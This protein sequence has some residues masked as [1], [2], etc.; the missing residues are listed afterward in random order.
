MI[1]VNTQQGSAEWH[2]LRCGVVTASDAAKI[3]QPGAASRPPRWFALTDA[4]L[5]AR[6]RGS[7]QMAVQATL[8][9]PW[10][11]SGD[12]RD[13]RLDRGAAFRPGGLSIDE[14]QIP[15]GISGTLL[16]MIERG[17]VVEV[18]PPPDAEPV[19]APLRVSSQRDGYL[20]R[21][22]AEEL[23]QRPVDPFMGN[24]WTERGHEGEGPAAE[25]FELITGMRPQ[26]VG[27]IFRDETRTVGCSPDWGIFEGDALAATAEVKNFAEDRHVAVL[28]SGEMPR[29]NV[30]QVQF[31]TWVTGCPAWFLSACPPEPD[32][33]VRLPP[34]IE[35][36]DPDPRWHDAFDEHVPA[37]VEELI[38][39]RARLLELGAVPAQKSEAATEEI[40]P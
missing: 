11:E 30:P 36:V 35:R 29:E 37:L 12:A 38:E 19:Q 9:A 7:V 39:K 5:V 1:V 6:L 15:G 23:L 3:V 28:L 40:Q 20:Y 14:R 18:D 22:L 8:A 4:G 21:L 27:F 34:L 13:P 2:R 24:Y 32:G 26:A 25:T 31:Q 10:R 17:H 16:T 33:V